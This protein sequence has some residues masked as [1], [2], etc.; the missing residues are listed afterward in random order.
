MNELISVVVSTY[1]RP[2]A[3][4]VVLRSLSRQ[5]D[6]NFEVLVA[7]DGSGPQTRDVIEAWRPR[8]QVPVKHVWQEDKGFRLSEIR[9]RAFLASAGRYFIWLDGDCI[10]PPAF[11]AAHRA[12]AEPGYF[13][14]GNRVLMSQALSERII[15][16]GLEPETWAF[17]TWIRLRLTGEVNRIVPLLRLPLG[18]LR[19]LKERDWEGVRGGNMAFFREDLERADGFDMSYEGWGPEDSD[20]VIRV[21]RSGTKRK[22][23]RFA[24]GVLHLWHQEAD[25]SR[26]K[27]NRTMLDTLLQNDRVRALKGLSEFTSREPGDTRASAQF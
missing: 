25:R 13:V 11:V 7:D 18:P 17:S 16:E 27:G 21:L 23:G 8:L 24:T 9:N 6:T 4:A 12:L 10:T 2:D 19:K 20:L 1:N 26:L 14:G 15:A 22:D 5:S 3:L